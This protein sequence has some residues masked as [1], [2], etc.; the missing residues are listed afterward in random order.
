[1]VKNKSMDLT[2]GSVTKNLLLFVFP[3]ILSNLLQHLYTVA[4]RIVVGQFAENGTAALAAVGSTGAAT[5]LILSLF[6]GLAVGVNI[7]CSNLLGAGEDRR[8]RTTMHTSLILAAMVG[9]FLLLVGQFVTRPLLVLMNVPADMLDLACLYVQIFFL[10]VPA[11]LV[12]NAGAAILR[13]HGDARRPMIILAVSGLVNVALNLV[14][15]IFLHMSVAGVAL[16]TVAAQ[17]VSAVWVLGILFSPR[18]IFKLRVKELQVH[19]QAAKQVLAVGIPCGV[20][21]IAFNFSNMILQ[22]TVN[23]FGTVVVAGNVAADSVTI[24]AHQVLVSFYSG[25]VSFV[26]QNYG[27]RKYK[28]V[29]RV[30]ATASLLSCSI[31]TVMGLLCVLFAKPLMGIFDSDPAVILAG[32]PKL[33]IYSFYCGIFAVSEV[34]LGALRGMKRSMIP[35]MIN[36]LS[37]CGVRILWTLVFF[38]LV[39]TVDMVYVCYP[40]SWAV[41]TVGLLVAYLYY[42]RRMQAEE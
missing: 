26:G 32:E 33:R 41:S 28:R 23:T 17:I 18:D 21:S 1:M 6:N 9:V 36:I 39:P 19:K 5:S 40:I 11:S 29:D 31:V 10:G 13:A 16:A 12:Y 35:S 38:P 20:N 2:T 15:V 22:S 42:R 4:D 30:T 3:I 24:L 27:A 8:L 34:L 37:I 25:T 7:L 14:L